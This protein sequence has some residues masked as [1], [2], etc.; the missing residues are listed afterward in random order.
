MSSQMHADSKK[1][2][3]EARPGMHLIGIGLLKTDTV[4]YIF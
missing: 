3:V 2:C 4:P 1:I